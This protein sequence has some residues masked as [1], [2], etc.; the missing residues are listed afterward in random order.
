MAILKVRKLTVLFIHCLACRCCARIHHSGHLFKIGLAPEVHHPNLTYLVAFGLVNYTVTRLWVRWPGF[1]S[2]QDQVILLFFS[3][4]LSALGPYYTIGTG[5][6]SS[7]V[8]L[9]RHKVDQRLSI[10]NFIKNYL[11]AVPISKHL[12]VRNTHTVSA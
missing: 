1:S 10:S 8:K 12:E 11:T 5:V 9:L 6:L 7:E 4:S 2:W 3:I